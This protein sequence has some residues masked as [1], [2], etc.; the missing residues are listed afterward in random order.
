MKKKIGILS[1]CFVLMSYL[2]ISPVIADISAQFPDVDISLVQMIITIP[3]LMAIF[4][5]LIAGKLA[6]RFYK[7]TL[8]LTAMALIILGAFLSLF[9]NGSVYALLFCTAVMGIGVG[10]LVTVT[11]DII[12]DYYEGSE[13]NFMMGLQSAFIG[14]GAMV[15]TLLGGWLSQFG[16]KKVYYSFLLLIPCFIFC[17]LWLPKGKLEKKMEKKEKRRLPGYVWFMSVA[18]FF[19]MA[20]QN[21]YNTNVSL[22][23]SETQLGNATMAGVA[24]SVNSLAGVIV[25][26]LL[27]KIMSKLKKYTLSLS[28]LCVVLGLIVTYIG[29]SVIVI[30]IG[31]FLVGMGFAIYPPATTCLV[32]EAVPD[33]QRSMALGISFSLNNIGGAMSPV[34]VNTL[35]GWFAPTVQIKFLI[36]AIVLGIVMIIVT[37]KFKMEKTKS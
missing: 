22:Y 13:R 28:Y 37:L 3:S 16:W 11:A 24:T 15:F 10:T 8:I 18:V 6:S 33:A 21:T 29:G 4:M 35:S 9:L 25:G 26:C 5:T 14:G 17:L 30:V 20:F 7:R 19:F 27:G 34:I 1:S 32:S 23:L 2:A 36:S 31:G 12:C